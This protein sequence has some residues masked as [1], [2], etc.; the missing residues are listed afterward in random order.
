M[1]YVVVT[2]FTDKNDKHIYRVG[3]EF[4]HSGADVSTER[5]AEL[6]SKSN[7]R[8]EVLIKAIDEEL[9]APQKPEIQP[10]S[11][12]TEVFDEIIDKEKKPPKKRNKKEK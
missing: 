11:D 2:D 3:D 7:M 12:K 9:K 8:G 4:P 10:V 5:V 6:T 1:K